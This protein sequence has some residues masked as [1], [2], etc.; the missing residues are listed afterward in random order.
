[1]NA[2][3]VRQWV[4]GQPA[5]VQT[6]WAVADAFI[7]APSPRCINGR[8]SDGK[9]PAHKP[10]E[11]HPDSSDDVE[12]ASK[13]VRTARYGPGGRVAEAYV[14]ADERPPRPAAK[15]GRMQHDLTEIST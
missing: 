10:S 7:S 9:K 4:P 12:A 15:I 14:L 2:A 3:L 1:M 8:H 13:H 11:P 5:Q 6:P